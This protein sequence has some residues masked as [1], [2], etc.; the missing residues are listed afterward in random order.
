MRRALNQISD[1][2]MSQARGRS[3]VSAQS[4]EH[5]NIRHRRFQ[6]TFSRFRYPRT[7]CITHLFNVSTCSSEPIEG[8]QRRLPVTLMCPLT[9]LHLPLQV[10]KHILYKKDGNR[11]QSAP[12]R[13]LQ[14]SRGKSSLGFSSGPLF[15]IYSKTAEEE[16]NKIVECRQKDADGILV[17]VSPP[18]GIHGG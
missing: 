8:E 6:A 15:F 1:R 12:N 3:F 18:V 13:P 9:P 5:V 17:F 14:P 16:D 4:C 7:V 11:T 2:K 10:H